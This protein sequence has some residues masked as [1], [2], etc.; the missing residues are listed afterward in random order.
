MYR[1]I[2]YTF[3]RSVSLVQIFHSEFRLFKFIKA[4]DCRNIS[5]LETVKYAYSL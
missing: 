3:E 2:S 5:D 4:M 1:L